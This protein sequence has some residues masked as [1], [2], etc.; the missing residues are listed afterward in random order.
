MSAALGAS[1][2][3]AAA[4]LPLHL[5][6]LIVVAVVAESRLPTAQAGW[7]ATAYMLGQMLVVLALPAAGY[8]LLRRQYAFVAAAVLLGAVATS[9]GLYGC[10]VLLPWF[11]VGAACGALQFLG[12]T[13][14]AAAPDRRLA[15]ALRLA[16][17][18]LVSGC[19]IVGVQFS[20]GFGT[21][22]SLAIQLSLV[23]AVLTGLGLVWYRE[24]GPADQMR[25]SLEPAKAG[26]LAGLLVVF[27]LFLGQPGFWAFALQGV[28]RRG[29]VLEHVAYAIA[30]CKASTGLVLLITALRGAH[31][32][33][34]TDLLWPGVAVAGGVLG[35]ALARH[36]ESFLVGLLLWELG[37]NV[38]AVRLQVA[39]VQDNPGMAGPW[40]TSAVFLGAATGPVLHGMTIQIGIPYAFVAYACVSAV[41]P[42]GWAMRQNVRN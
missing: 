35:M 40:L 25:G 20:G 26:S 16:V 30:F 38:L 4:S 13:T 31:G 15:F 39:V 6:P 27:L 41:V 18:L 1:L 28:Q 24:P 3:S 8:T 11:F 22:G 21:Y 19:A 10:P 34:R 9:R 7:I 37:L 23:F 17:T 32:P 14:A 36:P 42:F 5:M 12:T 29:V 2:L 33:P